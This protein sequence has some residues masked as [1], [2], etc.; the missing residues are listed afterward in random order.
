MLFRGALPYLFAYHLLK[1][2]LFCMPYSDFT[3][4]VGSK[5]YQTRDQARLVVSKPLVLLPSICTDIL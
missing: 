4:V 5:L 1:L 2:T 3:F